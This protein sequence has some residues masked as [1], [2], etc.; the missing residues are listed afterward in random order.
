MRGHGNPG[1]VA[2]EGP[3]VGTRPRS[4]ADGLRPGAGAAVAVVAAVAAAAALGAGGG[5]EHAATVAIVRALMVGAPLAIGLIALRRRSGE[6]FAAGLVATG[7]VCL[8]TTLAES[9]DPAAYTAGRAAGWVVEILLVYVI[10]AFP[11]G[12]LA[13]IDRLIVG[14]TAAIIAVFFAPALLLS[15]TLHTPSATSCASDCPPNALQVVDSEPAFVEVWLCPAGFIALTLVAVALVARLVHRTTSITPLTRQMYLPIIVLAGVRAVA[16]A[17]AGLDN[18][19]SDDVWVAGAAWVAALA[20]PAIA[21]AFGTALLRWELFRARALR[22]LAGSICSVP[23]ADMLRATLASALEDPSLRV[24][25]PAAGGGWTDDRGR[26][27]DAD[28]LPARGVSEVR[29]DGRVVAAIVHDAVLLDEPALLDATTAIAVAVLAH[30]RLVGESSTALGELRRSRARLAA[31]GAHERRRIERELRDGAEQRLA[32]L[33]VAFPIVVELVRSDP[34]QGLVRLRRLEDDVEAALDEIRT[35]GHG[36][37]PPLLADRGIVAALR[38]RALAE[39]LPLRVEV[40]GVGRCRSEVESAVY[41]CVLDALRRMVTETAGP[42]ARAVL[43]LTEG[44]DLRFTLTIAGAALR[45]PGANEPPPYERLALVGGRAEL[46]ATPDG[47]S[48]LRG[49]VPSPL[50]T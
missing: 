29:V 20:I 46:T 30:Q 13:R 45:H 49:V 34:E 48:I 11:T 28:A 9:A 44:G 32:A 23:D 6:R 41:F 37:C 47:G 15:E 18:H 35:L 8:V 7:I 50:P 19:A 26:F 33:R 16:V 40:H 24:V 17:V 1:A 38:A 42:A 31:S 2:V 36:V 4:A 21:L 5:S 10:L 14:T 22:R 3:A 39:G 12:R 27:V 43:E 25:L